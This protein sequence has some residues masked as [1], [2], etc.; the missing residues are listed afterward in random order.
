MTHQRLKPYNFIVTGASGNIGRHLV[1]LLEAQGF[2]ILALGRDASALRAMYANHPQ[3]DCADYSALAEQETCDTL[4]HLAVRNNDRPGSLE[5]FIQ[6]NVDFARD[7]GVQFRR[8]DGR[9]FIN[10]SSVQAFDPGN[11]SPYAVSKRLAQ[12]ELSDFLGDRLDNVHIGY[13]HSGSYYGEKLKTLNRFG[14]IGSALFGLFKTLKPTTSAGSLATYAVRTA[15]RLPE[16][17]I[18]TDDLARSWT[19]RAVTRAIDLAAAAIILILLLPLIAI[20]W[21][22]IRLG[23]PGPAIFAQTRVGKGQ[24]PFTLY[25]FRTMKRD[26]ASVGTHEVGVSAVTKAGKFLRKTKLD[27]LPQAINLLRGE[28]TLVGPRPC[29]PV[30]EELVDARSALG[31]FAMKPGI[32]GYAQIREIDMSRPQELAQSDHIYM[33]LQSLVLNFKIILLTAFGRGRGDRVAV[34]GKP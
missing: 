29:L 27:E 9:R 4:I 32:T 25:K 10:I 30:Q 18:L 14:A 28:M 1:P 26:T 3:V 34:P 22:V 6:V 11:S 7:V 17:R 16:P 23:S 24:A 21:L 13:F 20:L 8:M 5:E 19:Y 12:Q 33:K 2:Q 15:N 31:V